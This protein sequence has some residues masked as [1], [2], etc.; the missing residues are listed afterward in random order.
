[1]VVFAVAKLAS[2]VFLISLESPDFRPEVTTV[3]CC[4]YLYSLYSL[5]AVDYMIV[6]SFVVLLRVLGSKVSIFIL[7]WSFLCV[8]LVCSI[9][10]YCFFFE[11]APGKAISASEIL[12]LG[13]ISPPSFSWSLCKFASILVKLCYVYNCNFS[14]VSNLA[15]SFQLLGTYLPPFCLE[16]PYLLISKYFS[17]SARIFSLCD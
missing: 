10:S 11:T 13:T 6:P 17:L 8:K 12:S 15:A 4:W 5:C 1:M 9:V 16:L 14:I 2:S 7:F 3:W